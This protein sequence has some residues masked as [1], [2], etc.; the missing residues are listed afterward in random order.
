MNK[1]ILA[2]AIAAATV[3][4]HVSAGE[5]VTIY[6]RTNASLVMVDDDGGEVLGKTLTT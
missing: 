2:A 6:G 3:A 1:K 5:N 4:P